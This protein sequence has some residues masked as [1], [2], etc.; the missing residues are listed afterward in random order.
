MAFHL[1]Q[2]AVYD[3]VM[4]WGVS[5]RSVLLR[6]ELKLYFVVHKLGLQESLVEVDQAVKAWLY[7]SGACV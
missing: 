6:I 2:S 1:K 4:V 7:W 5:V 3:Q